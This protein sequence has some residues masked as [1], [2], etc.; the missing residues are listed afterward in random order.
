MSPLIYFLVSQIVLILTIYGS[1][2]AVSRFKVK[3]KQLT[4]FVVCGTLIAAYI[5][6]G[7]FFLANLHPVEKPQFK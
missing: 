7:I 2:V 3:E 6:W 4:N 1:R 5:S